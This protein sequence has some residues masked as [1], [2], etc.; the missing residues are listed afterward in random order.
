MKIRTCN[1]ITISKSEASPLGGIHTDHFEILY[2]TKGSAKFQWAHNCSV[3]EAPAIFLISPSTPHV[4]ESMGA[5]MTCCFLEI[6]EVD[7]P[8]FTT[9]HVDRWNLM[10]SDKTTSSHTLLTSTMQHSLDF[11][12]HLFSTREARQHEELEQVCL[13]EV[14]KIF[15]LITHILL[16][17]SKQGSSGQKKKWSAHETVDILINYMEWRYSDEITLE[18]LSDLVHLNPSY[19]I[20][21]FKEQTQCTPFEYLQTLRMKAAVSYLT[22]SDL[23]LRTIVEKTGFNSIHYFCRLFKKKYGDSP[24][25]WRDQLHAAANAE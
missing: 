1:S 25:R 8:F 16:S 9:Y 11:I 19:L 3:V 5:E 12:Y 15:K 4:L 14:Q 17:A 6:S 13:L 23:P 10:Q 2:I 22:R 24:V 7:D 18:M 20:R 21:V